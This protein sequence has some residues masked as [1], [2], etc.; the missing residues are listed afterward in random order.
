MLQ[1]YMWGDD[2]QFGTGVIT[3]STFAPRCAQHGG[4]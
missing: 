2:Q 3:V 1:T 4:L